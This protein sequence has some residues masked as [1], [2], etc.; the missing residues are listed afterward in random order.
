MSRADRD[1]DVHLA[2]PGE[3]LLAGLRVAAELERRVLLVQAPQALATLS[4]SPFV[5]GVTAKLITGSGKPSFGSSTSSSWSASRSPVCTSFSFATAPMSPAPNASAR[6]WSLPCSSSSAPMRSFALSRAFD[7][8]RVG[9]DRARETRKSVIR[10]AN[11]S[12][13]VLKT[14]AASCP[15]T[16]IGDGLLRRRRH[17]LDDQ[18]EQRVRA[19]VLRRDA[20]RDRDRARRS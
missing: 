5:F 3:E 17:A 12:A 16:S 20:A 6:S 18:V 15:S 10:P 13:T 19:E 2:H 11:G 9:R 1:L 4:S 8:R 14:N 7:E